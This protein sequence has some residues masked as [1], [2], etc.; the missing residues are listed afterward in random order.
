MGHI[1]PFSPKKGT[2]A[3]RMP[4]VDAMTVKARARRLREASGR[5]K[6]AWLQG[7]IGSRQKV[8]VEGGNGSGHAENFAPVKVAGAPIG[9]IVTVRIAAVD[10]DGLIGVTE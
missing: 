6:A 4:Q 3:A 5:R 10:Q 9:E 2:P 8:L 7:Q 1:F